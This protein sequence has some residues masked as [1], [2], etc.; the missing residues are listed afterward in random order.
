MI[1]HPKSTFGQFLFI[2]TVRLLIESLVLMIVVMLIMV[3]GA[4]CYCIAIHSAPAASVIAFL[5]LPLFY[6]GSL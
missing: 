3:C 1:D 6:S 5:S 2:Q 4:C